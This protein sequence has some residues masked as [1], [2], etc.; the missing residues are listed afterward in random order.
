[1][2]YKNEKFE[3]EDEG[4]KVSS[5][6]QLKHFQIVVPV[7]RTQQD[8]P[9][10]RAD[11]G[12]F[13]NYS[14]VEKNQKEEN[15]NPHLPFARHFY[16]AIVFQLLCAISLACYFHC[17]ILALEPVD[18]VFDACAWYESQKQRNRNTE[19]QESV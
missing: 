1:M 2:C 5:S 14:I 10:G 9:T 6:V 17:E 3:M 13:L 8:H 7:G 12:I 4:D 15:K 16:S 19:Q 11:G 18:K